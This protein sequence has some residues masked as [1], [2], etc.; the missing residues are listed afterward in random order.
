[1]SAKSFCSSYH[2]DLVS[3]ESQHELEY[4]MNASEGNYDS[5]GKI[6]LLG[7][8][9]EEK[10]W[11]SSSWGRIMNIDLANVEEIDKDG[12]CLSLIKKGNRKF[13]FGKITCRNQ[14]YAFICQRTIFKME[15]W[16]DI[17]GR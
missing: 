7:G 2:M 16:T 13:S 17:F 15:H 1:M 10:G 3:L 11:T 12:K 8:V 9:Y 4:F 6:T 5:F 14:P